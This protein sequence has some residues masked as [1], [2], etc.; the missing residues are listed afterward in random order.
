MYTEAADVA[1]AVREFEREIDSTY[2]A[3]TTVYLL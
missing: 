1:S 2:I 3:F